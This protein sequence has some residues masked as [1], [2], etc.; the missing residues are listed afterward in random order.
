M[1]DPAKVA[2]WLK[3]NNIPDVYYVNSG[4][5]EEFALHFKQDIPNSDMYG[6]EE[7]EGADTDLGGHL[8]IYDGQLHYDSECLEGVADWKDLPYYKRRIAW[9]TLRKELGDTPI[10][11]TTLVARMPRDCDS[12]STV[13]H[14]H[15]DGI[16][17]I[18][19]VFKPSGFKRVGISRKNSI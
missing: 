17:P 5:C 19:T 6:A 7:F 12:S 4:M 8:W 3:D 13:M 2:Q 15:C 9:E 1:L 10:K 16:Y 18:R 11:H 14:A